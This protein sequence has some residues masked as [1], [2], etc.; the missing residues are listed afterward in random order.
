MA[1]KKASR[2]KSAVRAERMKA[3]WADPAY[4][5]RMAQLAKAQRERERAAKNGSPPSP[6][7]DGG[8]EA[9]SATTSAKS[10]ERTAPAAVIASPPKVPARRG[11]TPGRAWR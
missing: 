3:K 11:W 4:R 10:G 1:R 8:T 2:V 7:A 9:A 5:E 6:S